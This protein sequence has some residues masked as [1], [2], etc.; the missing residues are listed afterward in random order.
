[1]DEVVPYDTSCSVVS[2]ILFATSLVCGYASFPGESGGWL[3]AIGGAWHGGARREPRGT[4]RIRWWCVTRP[5]RRGTAAGAGRAV[6]L[7]WN[8]GDGDGRT[9][10][11]RP[12]PGA[13][14]PK[15]C[16]DRL[17]QRARRSGACKLQILRARGTSSRG[18]AA[19]APARGLFTDRSILDF[20]PDFRW[21]IAP[22]SARTFP[23]PRMGPTG[24]ELTRRS[25]ACENCTAGVGSPYR[26]KKFSRRG[27]NL[28]SRR[29]K[30]KYRNDVIT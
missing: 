7:A 2:R 30:Y 19:L 11:A 21:R 27:M 15:R 8:K 29:E 3:V 17:C 16:H 4:H 13:M 5:K 10:R 6:R 24:R 14:R 22:A 9:G 20:S 12:L 18:D 25:R 28:A 23:R 1:M 26:R